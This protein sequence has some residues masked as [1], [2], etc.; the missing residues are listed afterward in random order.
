MPGGNN[1]IHPAQ[2]DGLRRLFMLS[3][4]RDIRYLRKHLPDLQQM[5]LQYARADAAAGGGKLDLEDEL[6]ALI[7][8]RTFILDQAD[9]R[10]ARQFDERI[11]RCKPDML[12]NSIEICKLVSEILGLYQQVRKQLSGATQINWLAS[13][14]DMKQQLGQLVYKGFLQQTPW[15]HLLQYPRYFKAMS[16]RLD[17]LGHAAVR[18][19]Q[20]MAEMR[21]LQSN[22]QQRQEAVRNKGQRDERLE[23]IGWMLQEWRISLFAQALKTNYPVSEKRIYKR[24]RE[25]GL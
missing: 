9:V 21:E 25:L 5:R 6:V 2:H 11:E 12:P 1:D 17:K 13:T 16:M 7:V 22:W 14:E 24:W 8:D 19:Q 20:Q 23:E 4:P 18:D 15:Q 3:M 10:D